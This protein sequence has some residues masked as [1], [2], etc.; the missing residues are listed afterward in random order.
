M[1]K[2]GRREVPRG[3]FFIKGGKPCKI[4]LNIRRRDIAGRRVAAV[5]AEDEIISAVE[6]AKI[7]RRNRGGK[8]REIGNAV[9]RRGVFYAA[10]RFR[11]GQRIYIGEKRFYARVVR[12]RAGELGNDHMP[13]ESGEIRQLEGC[14]VR[15][16]I[17]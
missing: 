8:K 16:P 3:G 15:S 2:R 7:F 9:K 10:R 17:P 4:A 5:V 1:D 14:P 13:G 11:P 6:D 12:R